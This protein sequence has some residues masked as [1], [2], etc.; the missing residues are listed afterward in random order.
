MALPVRVFNVSFPHDKQGHK[1]AVKDLCHECYAKGALN[2]GALV[3]NMPAC[4][5]IAFFSLPETGIAIE[6]VFDSF[7]NRT[8]DHRHLG[9][10]LHNI[11]TKRLAHTCCG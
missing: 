10:W 9:E 7:A 3:D 2:L 11:C 1:K 5:Q 8:A 4:T 6:R